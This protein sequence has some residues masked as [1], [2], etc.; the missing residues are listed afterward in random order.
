MSE[1]FQQDISTCVRQTFAKADE[2]IL[3]GFL[4]EIDPLSIVPRSLKS[5]SPW[6]NLESPGSTA[7]CVLLQD[8]Q[9]MPKYHVFW[10]G[11]TRAVLCRDG[12]AIQLTND[13]RV[14][15]KKEQ[16]RIASVDGHDISTGRLD[17]SLMVTRAFGDMRHKLDCVNKLAPETMKKVMSMLSTPSMKT[18]KKKC[19]HTDVQVK[20]AAVEDALICTP[21]I[22]QDYVRNT[23]EFILIGS[24]GLFD[25]LSNQQAVNVVRHALIEYHG[26]ITEAAKRLTGT[27]LQLESSDNVSVVLI[28]LNIEDK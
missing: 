21:E 20:E 16:I 10:C 14:T 4:D 23:D 19:V 5:M 25:V 22:V 9:P 11:D 1:L 8:C 17:G 18:I 7:C 24:D 6:K 2:E 15:N 13:H 27:A 28:Q 12:A 26:N 3:L